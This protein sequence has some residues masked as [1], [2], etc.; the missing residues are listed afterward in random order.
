MSEPCTCFAVG[1]KDAGKRLDRFLKERIPGLSRAR[2]QD[3]IRTRI[4][5]SW[6]PH[7]RPSTPVRAGGEVRIGWTPLA[8][9]PLGILF[10]VL[11]RGEGWLAIDKPAGIPVH[12]VNLVR[13]NSVIRMLRRQEG[14]ES[15]RLVHRLD[16]ETTGVLLVA[17]DGAAARV[18]ATAFEAGGVEKEY[19]ALVRGELDREEG[20][21]DLPIGDADRRI[22]HVRRSVEAG[23]QPARTAWRVERRLPGRTLLRVRPATGRRHQIR[24]H[25]AAVG[26]PIVGDI[27]YGRPDRAYLDLVRGTGDA[28]AHEGVRRQML[29][30]ARLSF[31]QP[32]GAPATVEAPLPDDL[33]EAIRGRK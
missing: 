28:R 5:L 19:L 21:I 29:H 1:A 18:L 30:C 25:M 2:L 11:A 23:G 14:R 24:V 9:E 33:A 8:E 17:E 31:R 7:P 3:A 20:I 32:S 10:P 27:L 12:P 26:H 6:L 13:E 4:S 16:R 15:L 22:V